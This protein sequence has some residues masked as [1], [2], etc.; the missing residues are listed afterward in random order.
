MNSDQYQLGDDGELHDARPKR[1]L[2]GEERTALTA[3]F[4]AFGIIAAFL[5]GLMSG[6]VLGR[7]TTESVPSAALMIATMPTTPLVTATSPPSS[8][9]L[10]TFTPS[11]LPPIYKTL[12]VNEY[13]RF[14]VYWRR[15]LWEAAVGG[16]V[17]TEDFEKD[18]AD[19]GQL[20]FPYLTGNE[21]FLTGSSIAQILKDQSLSP[22]GSLLHF[23]DWQS[24]LT[25]GFPNATTASAFGFDF[26]SSEGWQLTFNGFNVPL[27]NGRKGFV[28]VV[29]ST[30]YPRSFLL[31]SSEKGQ[32]GLTL[33]NISYLSTRAR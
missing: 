16:G 29:F 24:G 25:F 7:S 21:F 4:L 11:A 6:F 9:P 19:Y 18:D 28:G 17:I 12:N 2:S 30:D 10:T 27:P 20:S 26:R 14:T 22:T 5:I 23:R 8:T 13:T 32:G 31:S 3:I 1:K 33:D 15:E